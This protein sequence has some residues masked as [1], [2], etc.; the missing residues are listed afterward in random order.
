MSTDDTQP[1]LQSVRDAFARE[2]RRADDHRDILASFIDEHPDYA[3]DRVSLLTEGVIRSDD[4]DDRLP[5]SPS[6]SLDSA[7]DADLLYAYV[8]GMEATLAR[9]DDQVALDLD[10]PRS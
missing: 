8:R 4:L 3:D 7:R 10:D 1:A 2:N 6:D 5:D 9:F